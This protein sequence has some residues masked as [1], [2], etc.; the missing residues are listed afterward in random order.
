VDALLIFLNFLVA[1]LECYYLL[2]KTDSLLED[3]DYR[4]SVAFLDEIRQY[5]EYQSIRLK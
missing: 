1:E 4:E 2:R 3:L 5:P